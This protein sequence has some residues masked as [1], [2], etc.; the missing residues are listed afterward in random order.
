MNL[1]LWIL[2]IYPMQRHRHEWDDCLFLSFL[3]YFV[4]Y[5]DTVCHLNFFAIVAST[6]L[7][8]SDLPCFPLDLLLFVSCCDMDIVYYCLP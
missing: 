1:T 8:L 7:L 3:H 4:E 5:W 2:I 6:I